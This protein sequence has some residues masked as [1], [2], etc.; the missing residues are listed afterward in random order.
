MRK[1][2]TW[3]Q[4]LVSKHVL[5]IAGLLPGETLPVPESMSLPMTVLIAGDTPLPPLLLF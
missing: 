1:M 5:C 4:N 3:Q 2:G